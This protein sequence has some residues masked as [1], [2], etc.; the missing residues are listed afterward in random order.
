MSRNGIIRRLLWNMTRFAISKIYCCP[1]C[2]PR[3]RHAV[4]LEW[5]SGL[6]ATGWFDNYDLTIFILNRKRE[7]HAMAIEFTQQKAESSQDSKS[8]SDSDI[9]RLA[10]LEAIT[11]KLGEISSIDH[12]SRHRPHLLLPPSTKGYHSENYGNWLRL[13]KQPHQ[14]ISNGCQTYWQ[15][16]PEISHHWIGPA[17]RQC[18][19]DRLHQSNLQ[20]STCLARWS[21][22][23]QHEHTL[24]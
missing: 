24:I 11:T 22:R 7:T 6:P 20:P 18:R 13:S 12:H 15:R 4:A 1:Y 10:K 14:P 5:S 16:N 8:T 23:R 9:T 3:I 2:F 19:Q 17:I 21:I